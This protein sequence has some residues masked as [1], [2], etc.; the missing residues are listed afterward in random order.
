MLESFWNFT[1]FA[2]CAN[3]TGKTVILLYQS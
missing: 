3:D 1:R 2:C